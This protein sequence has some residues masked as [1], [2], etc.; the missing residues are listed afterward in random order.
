MTSAKED[1]SPK[2]LSRYELIERIG[3]GG[4]G[5]VHIARRSG[6]GGFVK[7]VAIKKMLPHL[8]QSE[9][10]VRMFLDEARI[11]AQIDHKNVIDIYDLGHSDGALYMV[12]EYLKGESLS[13]IMGKGIVRKTP[14]PV[15]LAAGIV[16]RFCRGLHHAHTLKDA[17]GTPL[18]IVHRDVSPQNVVVLF[19]GGVKLLDFG[20]AK[21]RER[22]SKTTHMDGA[23]GKY[24]YMSPEQCQG[25]GVDARSDIFAAGIVLWEISARRRLFN[26]PNKLKALQALSEARVAP[27]SR[28]NPEIPKALD[29][30]VLKALAKRP[31]NR[32]QSAEELADT[33]E[34]YL[35]TRDVQN[36]ERQLADY[37]NGGFA[38]E[39]KEHEARIIAVTTSQ[40]VELPIRRT[41]EHYF[42]L[43]PNAPDEP[44]ADVVVTA[45]TDRDRRADND[46]RETRG[47]IPYTEDEQDDDR[48]TRPLRQPDETDPPVSTRPEA[49]RS[50]RSTIISLASDL[51][52]ELSEGD[53]RPTLIVPSKTSGELTGTPIKKI[54]TTES[55]GDPSPFA[56]NMTTSL[57]S[58]VPPSPVATASLVSPMP[59]DPRTPLDPFARETPSSTTDIHLSIRKKSAAKRYLTIA[60]I[61]LIAGAALFFLG[62]RQK[63]QPAILDASVTAVDF[64][65][66]TAKHANAATRKDAGE[67][68]DLKIAAAHLPAKSP[69][70]ALAQPDSL[71]ATS[72]VAASTDAEVDSTKPKRPVTNRGETIKPPP[73]P[74]HFGTLTL[75]TFP[76]SVIY[77]RGKK[78]GPTPLV[79]AKL[80][81]GRVRLVAVNGEEGIRQTLTLKITRDQNLRKIV[82][83]KSK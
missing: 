80:P 37:M 43:I 79:N 13:R 71:V 15:D 46:H 61:L 58:P 54:G 16:A 2:R 19:D 40:K 81:A 68:S 3:F 48:P 83:L 62:R 66:P 9:Q 56:D 17:H 24:S 35:D 41:G 52:A 34:E 18:Q 32:F 55:D 67:R 26:N 44:S 63:S 60:A 6:I 20:V 12:M 82:K 69:D 65:T 76:W 64:G 11:A 75:N 42:D 59:K 50:K 4:M 74:R 78:L 30:I 77:Y 49:D 53:S 51:L 70:A 22:L 21:A 1:N 14:L 23:K 27:P 31:E 36:V 47:L 25:S 38:E 8:Q 45:Y 39:L 33:I 5:E 73:R 29:A 10:I 72:T 57:A 28:V 7:V